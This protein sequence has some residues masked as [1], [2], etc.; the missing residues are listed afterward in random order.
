MASEPLNKNLEDEIAAALGD[1]SIE[2]LMVD[3]PKSRKNRGSREI[4][5]G[6]IA[7]IHGPNVLV[8]FG[9]RLQGCCPTTQFIELPQIG[10]SM[11]FVI[12][13]RDQDGMLVLSRKGAVQKAVWDTLDVG[14]VIEAT[15]TG[16][17]NGG[18]EL[19]LSGHN[20]FMPSGQVA[21]H[22]VEDL[23]SF[24]GEKFTCEVIELDKSSNRLVLSRKRVLLVEKETAGKELLATLTIGDT[25]EA[26]ITTIKPY[27]AFAD[28]G[29]IEGLI[30]ISEM[31]WD[32]VSDASKL[33]T[34][35]QTVMVKLLDI[36]QD[37]SPPRI[38]LG[39]KQLLKNPNT[40]IAHTQDDEEVQPRAE[41]NAMKK[42]R[43][44]F[45]KGP[46][47]GGIG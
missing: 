33:V 46:L 28:I 47:K 1:A 11:E 39:M 45:G 25:L 44:K 32:R 41:D 34:T 20:A 4:K 36:Q 35:G 19:E 40:T 37:H 22:H 17:N 29:G 8:E 10:D 6:I 42:L 14:Q 16:T 38:A 26:T 43:E 9:P 13:R 7:A 18:L 31:S 3:Q 15:C 5:S 30:H 12:E 24:V 21:L 2:D 23:S 27:G